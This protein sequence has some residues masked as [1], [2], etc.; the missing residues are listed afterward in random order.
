MHVRLIWHE[1]DNTCEVRQE[2]LLSLTLIL[3]REDEVLPTHDSIIINHLGFVGLYYTVIITKMCNGALF[4]SA[5]SLSLL[6]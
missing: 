4:F 5:L 2:L 1:A 6:E 3:L